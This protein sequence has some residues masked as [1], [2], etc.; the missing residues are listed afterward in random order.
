MIAKSLAALWAVAVALSIATAAEDKP[1][2]FEVAAI[3]PSGASS[4]F[5]FTVSPGGRLSATNMTLQRL[6]LFAYNL[7]PRQL[8]GAEGWI[9]SDRFDVVAKAPDG[10]LT[11]LDPRQAEITAPNGRA[12]ATFTVL[13]RNSESTEQ[14]RKMVQALLAERFQLKTHS[15]TKELPIYALVVGKNGPKMQESK[16]QAGPQ[17]RFAIGEISH[18]KR[19]HALPG[20]PP[21]SALGPGGAR[22]DW[23]QGRLRFHTSFCPRC[24]DDSEVPG[25]ERGRPHG[26]A[27][28]WVVAWAQ[29]AGPAVSRRKSRPGLPSSRQFKSTLG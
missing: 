12:V 22:P 5:S 4:H 10:S 14:F 23:A 27:A 9:M 1:Q 19:E 13:N 25:C 24:R 21:H 3:K 6:I 8:S 28:E 18:A 26:W 2:E 7:G 16:T 11:G 15:E 29:A 17:M 20:D